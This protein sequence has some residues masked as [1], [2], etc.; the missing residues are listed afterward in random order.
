M[1]VS[2]PFRRTCRQFANGHY[3]GSFN[4][5]PAEYTRHPKFANSPKHF[6]RAFLLLQDDLQKLFDYIE[7]ADTNLESYSFRLHEILTR[8]CIEIEANAKAILTE[9]GYEKSSDWNMNDYRKID[10][11]HRLS[12]YRV[13]IPDWKGEH[14]IRQPFKVWSD[15]KAPTW[16]KAYNH[17]KH[18]RHSN[19]GLANLQNVTDAICGLVAILSSQF[20]TEDFGP[21]NYV[22]TGKRGMEG[23]DVAIG[24]YFEVRFPDDW[25][26]DERYDF[27]WRA[28]EDDPDPFETFE[29]T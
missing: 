15:N 10:Q 3:D 17:A 29:Y 20:H 8:S 1:T 28:I 7:P 2:K 13:L 4:R 9:N 19:F 6:V 5:G 22:I 27:D 14:A 16:Y 12:S 24:G 23:F 11:S 18:D 21:I 26:T 25:P